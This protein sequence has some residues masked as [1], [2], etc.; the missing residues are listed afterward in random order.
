MKS[1]RTRM[2]MFDMDKLRIVSVFGTRPEA[3]KIPDESPYAGWDPTDPH[4]D[5]PT[6]ARYIP[7]KSG[8]IRLPE[9]RVVWMVRL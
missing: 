7:T 4:P 5:N 3:I 9:R 8:V 2:R 1:K 6:R